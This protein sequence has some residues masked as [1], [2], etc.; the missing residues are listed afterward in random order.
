MNAAFSKRKSNHIENHDHEIKL[1]T[2]TSAT[3]E[4]G[5]WYKWKKKRGSV[6]LV[7]SCFPRENVLSFR[8]FQQH[9]VYSNT[10]KIFTTREPFPLYL[11]I[12]GLLT[13][14]SL[15]HV[16][17]TSSINEQLRLITQFLQSKEK[18]LIIW[19]PTS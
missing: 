15:F 8:N 19:Q 12:D 7:T 14:F 18:N 11:I 1:F 10:I 16:K 13:K 3:S 4:S 9:W 6:P 17:S 5:S 2:K